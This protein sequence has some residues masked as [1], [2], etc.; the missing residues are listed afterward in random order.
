MI[1]PLY[2]KNIFGRLCIIRNV[3]VSA[4]YEALSAS[5]CIYHCPNVV[6]Y[7]WHWTWSPP[8]SASRTTP[9]G[10]GAWLHGCTKLCQLT[11]VHHEHEIKSPRSNSCTSMRHLGLLCNLVQAWVYG[12]RMMQV[13]LFTK[14]QHVCRKRGDVLSGNSLK[15]YV[16]GES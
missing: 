2:R 15:V 12:P 11:T 13:Y 3:A 7:H 4:V 9:M 5:I 16:A 6:V 14:T 8:F 1:I 10:R